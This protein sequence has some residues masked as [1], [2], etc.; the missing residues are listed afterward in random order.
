VPSEGVRGMEL[1]WTLSRTARDRGARILS[2]D[3]DIGP[4]WLSGWAWLISMEFG[5]W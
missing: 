3:I 1:T 4:V 2:Y 5:S